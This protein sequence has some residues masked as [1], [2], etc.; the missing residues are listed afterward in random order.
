MK[1]VLTKGNHKNLTYQD[2][3][4]IEE[5][6][7]NN[8]TFKAIGEDLCRNPKTIS[9][10]IKRGSFTREK[11]HKLRK[12]ICAYKDDCQI[13]NLCSSTYCKKDIPCS[14]CKMNICSQ[15][16]DQ[17]M[18]GQCSH[19]LKP[20]YVCNPCKKY[21]TCGYDKRW[22]RAN[23]ADDMYHER[24]SQSRIGIDLS[25]E[26]VY[27]LDELITPLLLKGQ[28]ITHIYATHGDKI[29]CSKRSLYN[30]IDQGVFRVRNIDLP[31]KVRYKPRRKQ[32]VFKF[33][34]TYREGRS[35][36]DFELFMSMHP[37]LNVVEMDVVEG[38]KGGKV[39]L[40]MLFRNCNLM[41]IFLMDKSTQADV[42]K[43]FNDLTGVFGV[44]G[45]K[46]L[47]PVILTDNGGCFKDP[48]SLESDEYGDLRTRIFY[49]DPHKSYQK[50]KLEKNHE[51][52]RYILPKGKAFDELT[53]DKVTLMA[54]HINSVVRASLN[55]KTPFELATLLLGSDTLTKMNLNHVPHDDVHLKPSLLK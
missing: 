5:R 51:F 32:Q 4:G 46:K 8:Y 29:K 27:L 47:F 10:E 44:E 55:D 38:K 7:N 45:M 2:R 41:L 24:M 12:G 31:R 20:P 26:E 11:N 23:H 37:N 30:Y 21:T 17:Y 52:I 6:L 15:Y 53:Q 1:K 49:C 50:G 39:F 22:Y 28:S 40:T 14:K 3:K 13:T 18:P 42:L 34:Q 16:C 54:N 19:L 36:T 25:P 48:D 43:V 9:R 33:D 35:Y